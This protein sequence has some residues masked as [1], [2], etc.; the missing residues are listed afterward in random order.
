MTSKFSKWVTRYTSVDELAEFLGVSRV[1]VYR[2]INRQATP[3]LESASEMIKF[4]KNKLTLDDIIK[5][6][7]R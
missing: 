4:S 7:T 5:G 3:T 2:W 1:T 6:T